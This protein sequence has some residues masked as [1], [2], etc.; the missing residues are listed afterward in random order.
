MGTVDIKPSADYQEITIK[1]FDQKGT[2]T[3]FHT[4]HFLLQPGKYHLAI[5]LDG[6]GARHL[7]TEVVLGSTSNIK[8]VEPQTRSNNGQ[9]PSDEATG[10]RKRWWQFWK[11]SSPAEK[12]TSARTDTKDASVETNTKESN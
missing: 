10:A 4:P 11:K 7:D 6:K 12:D 8:L 2:E 1:V 9:T 3:E 5:S